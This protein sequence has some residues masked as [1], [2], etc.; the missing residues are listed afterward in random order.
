ME[1]R[2]ETEWDG[3]SRK[4]PAGGFSEKGS[5]RKGGEPW[6]QGN[7]LSSGI[8][9]V[10]LPEALREHLLELAEAPPVPG[11]QRGGRLDLD[12]DDLS[13][14]VFENEINLRSREGPEMGEPGSRSEGGQMSDQFSVDEGFEEGAR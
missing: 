7:R 11:G 8:D 2:L 3:R 1:S 12:S 14:P 9:H 6:A 10:P 5:D 13:P 4:I